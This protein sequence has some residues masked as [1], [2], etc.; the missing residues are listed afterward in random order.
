M[1]RVRT[2]YVE[3]TWHHQAT[4]DIWTTILAAVRARRRLLGNI[5]TG[6]THPK[7]VVVIVD[8][9]PLIKAPLM[10]PVL[11]QCLGGTTFGPSAVH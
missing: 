11:I 6:S 2:V 7:K 10:V 1:A 9:A 3:L 5:K 4:G 8:A